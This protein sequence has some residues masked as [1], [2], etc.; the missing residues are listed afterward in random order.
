MDNKINIILNEHTITSPFIKKNI[1]LTELDKINSKFDSIFIGDI[2]NF[3]PVGNILPTLSKIKSLLNKGGTLV[4]EEF[5]QIEVCLGLIN[6]SISSD[7]FNSI[8]RNKN[9]LFSILDITEILSR[10]GFTISTKDID[11]LKHTITAT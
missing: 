5:D 10:G 4:I 7:N 1:N 9:N 2:L 3:L 11:S 8:I 6:D